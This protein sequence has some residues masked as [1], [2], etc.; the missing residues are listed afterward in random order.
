MKSKTMKEKLAYLSQLRTKTIQELIEKEQAIVKKYEEIDPTKNDFEEIVK[1]YNH[2]YS[3]IK[4]DLELKI[5]TYERQ[6]KALER[7]INE[8]EQKEQE[9]LKEIRPLIENYNSIIEKAKKRIIEFQ[10]FLTD[11]ANKLEDAYLKISPISKELGLSFSDE[12]I[13]NL[14]SCEELRFNL[15]GHSHYGSYELFSYIL[16]E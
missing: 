5:K 9:L 4:P 2:F 11:L 10:E 6:I 14:K 1:S 7:Q 8:Q 13:F 15:K 12:H 16:T 3:S